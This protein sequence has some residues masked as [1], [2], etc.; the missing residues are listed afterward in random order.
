MLFAAKTYDEQYNAIGI[1]NMEQLSCHYS[2]LPVCGT[3]QRNV[4]KNFNNNKT[5]T[6]TTTT[7]TT[8]I[9]VKVL[10]EE[11]TIQYDNES[12]QIFEDSKH[13]PLKQLKVIVEDDVKDFS[14][15]PNVRNDLTRSISYFKYPKG[16]QGHFYRARFTPF[17]HSID[18][19]RQRL[20]TTIN[21]A[22]LRT[23]HNSQLAI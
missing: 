21:N 20:Q 10:Q 2:P 4:I 5:A 16:Q 17:L 13:L 11:R 9:A 23:W 19:R 22:R 18:L 14:H 8:K 1:N 3:I 12:L 6:N 7:Q 15:P